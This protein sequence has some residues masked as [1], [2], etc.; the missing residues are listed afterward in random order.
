MEERV[1]EL[2]SRVAFQSKTIRDLDDVVRLF[3]DRV[4]RLEKRVSDLASEL[5]EG[6]AAV[7][8]VDEVPPHY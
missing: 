8:P 3:A 1:T 6:S 7:D 5:R 2:E 4:E